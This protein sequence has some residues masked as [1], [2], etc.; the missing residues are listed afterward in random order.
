MSEWNERKA[1]VTANPDSKANDIK[2]F[3]ESHRDKKKKEAII[4]L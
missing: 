1:I 2:W 3:K 4:K